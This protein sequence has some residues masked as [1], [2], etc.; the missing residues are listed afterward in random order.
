MIVISLFVC[1]NVFGPLEWGCARS[2]TNEACQLVAVRVERALR[3]K[4]T[5]EQ[6][7]TIPRMLF[8]T[9]E[10]P[11]W[12][13]LHYLY[14]S[15][16]AK[17]DSVR[18]GLEGIPLG[19]S[20][21]FVQ[22]APGKLDWLNV[23]GEITRHNCEIGKVLKQVAES[24]NRHFLSDF[25]SLMWVWERYAK[26]VCRE[27][28]GAW[29]SDFR[30]CDFAT[31]TC[32]RLSGLSPVGA[33]WQRYG[34]LNC[35]NHSAVIPSLSKYLKKEG[36]SMA[37]RVFAASGLN[38]LI[39]DFLG[40]VIIPSHVYE[41][42]REFVNSDLRQ[43][44]E[45]AAWHPDPARAAQREKWKIIYMAYLGCLWAW[46]RDCETECG[47]SFDGVLEPFVRLP[48]PVEDRGRAILACL[49]CLSGS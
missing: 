13:F 43:M 33:E 39:C 5:E 1:A 46:L 40:R 21:E 9:P 31:N 23:P 27:E 19:N 29:S 24:Q 6:R 34:I 20:L 12:D 36:P 14:R 11:R 10:K 16:M 42:L 35:A 25:F 15:F 2:S 17:L 28:G 49:A 41:K 45:G 38:K 37:E 47:K 7:E 32:R 48:G 4:G 30:E 18:L 22:I 26:Q 8:G 44:G 3:N